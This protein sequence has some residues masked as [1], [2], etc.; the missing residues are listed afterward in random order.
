[1]CAILVLTNNGQVS[2]MLGGF[3]NIPGDTGFVDICSFIDNIPWDDD[4]ADRLVSNTGPQL[5][6]WTIYDDVALDRYIIYENGTPVNWGAS[7]KPQETVGTSISN[8]ACRQISGTFF[9]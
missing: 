3:G 8:Q 2:N 4:P 7:G 9:N 6:T 1:M 5:L